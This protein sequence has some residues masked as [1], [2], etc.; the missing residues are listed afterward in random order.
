MVKFEVIQR[1][2]WPYK[3]KILQMWEE[4]LPGTPPERFEWMN[5]GNPA[6]N[7]IWLL[8]FQGQSNNLVG[9]TSVM[10]KRF[11]RRGKTIKAGIVGDIMVRSK[12][13]NLGIGLQLQKT[14]TKVAPD[15]GFEFLYV[16]PNE[17][18]KKLVQKAGFKK[19][20]SLCTLVRPITLSYYMEKYTTRGLSRFLCPLVSYALKSISRE[21]ANPD[22]ATFENRP[23]VDETLDLVW[24]NAVKSK[25]SLLSDHASAYLKWRYFQNPLYAFHLEAYKSAP[26]AKISGYALYTNDDDKLTIYDFLALHEND[27]MILIKRLLDIG[28]Q[29]NSKGLYIS[30]SKHNTLFKKLKVFGFLNT[31]DNLEIFMYGE[32]QILCTESCLFLGDRNI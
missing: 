13:R 11:C 22:N 18:S 30:L 7:A 5:Y 32:G 20:D 26:D 24:E 8:A 9:T 19:L 12:Y 23:S 16:V 21:T 4:N 10:P 25:S 29:S 2:P 1:D 28:K 17:N 3:Q 27:A 14:A 31:K 6:G 15:F